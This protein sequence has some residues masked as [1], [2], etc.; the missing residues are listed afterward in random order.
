MITGTYVD[1]TGKKTFRT[2]DPDKLIATINE[3]HKSRGGK[4][5]TKGA[6][7]YLSKAG[8]KGQL[9]ATV[10]SSVL[11]Y[12]FGEEFLKDS[13][14]IDRTYQD[15]VSL[16]NA[17]IVEE[18]FTTGEKAAGAAGAG[19]GASLFT[20]AGRKGLGKAFNF[21]GPLG[22]VAFNTI[23]GIDLNSG[24]DRAILGG[25][26]FGAKSVV[27]AFNKVTGNIKNKAGQMGARVLGIGGL[28]PAFAS[29]IAAGTTLPGALVLG[30]EGLYQ[31]AKNSQP[32]YFL[33]DD[34]EPKAFDRE[35]A[36]DVFPSMID[37]NE[38]AYKIAK[39][40]G[41]SYE[42]AVKEIDYTRLKNLKND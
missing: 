13:N 28:R 32:G 25:E 5:L 23:A 9:T 15:T 12:N 27:D 33:G 37:A 22:S 34:D 26:M 17:P 6:L 7:S 2:N 39:E 31:L 20:K 10:L 38:Q 19:V 3:A 36:A 18:N 1:R 16:G 24:V 35:N 30:G 4:P 21:L 14:I 29:R 41:I 42:D 40:K 8:K 11:G